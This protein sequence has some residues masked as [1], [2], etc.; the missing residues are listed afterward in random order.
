MES[1]GALEP[2][3]SLELKLSYLFLGFLVFKEEIFLH[4]K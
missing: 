1:K 3:F 2:R 4:E